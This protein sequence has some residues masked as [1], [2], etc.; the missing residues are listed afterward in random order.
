MEFTPTASPQN[1]QKL[2]QFLE[3]LNELKERY[4]Y[5]LGATLKYTTGGII[6]QLSVTDVVPS[7]KAIKPPKKGKK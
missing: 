6:P 4:Q 3:E 7:K 1:N 5:N 2:N